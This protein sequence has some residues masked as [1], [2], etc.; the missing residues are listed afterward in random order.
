VEKGIIGKGYIQIYTGNGKG[1]TTAALGLALRA[2]G[3]GLR[4]V[5]I[6]FMKGWIDYGE[7]GGVKMLA[8]RVELHQCG[9]DT[10]VNPKNPDQVDLDLAKKGLSL[11]EEAIR[12]K[13]ADILI[14]DEIVCTVSFNLIEEERILQLMKDKPVGME[15]ILTG[16]G[17]TEKMI[18]IADL[19][20]EMRDIKHYY[21]EGV[22]ARI[23]I[24]R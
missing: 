3:H 14:L 7:I 22:D 6:Q 4:T 11:A 16:R 9:R 15:L 8:P 18:E 13:Q 1:K 12:S 23:G 20:T 19:V 5:I 2:A 24:E 10:F 21:E 17:A